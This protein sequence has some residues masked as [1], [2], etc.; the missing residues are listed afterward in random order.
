MQAL[1]KLEP[2]TAQVIARPVYRSTEYTLASF[3]RWFCANAPIVRSY[4][5]ALISQLSEA[6]ARDSQ[7]R[8]DFMDFAMVQFDLELARSKS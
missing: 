2:I 7:S 5:D 4:W 3:A 1:P 8:H 6:E